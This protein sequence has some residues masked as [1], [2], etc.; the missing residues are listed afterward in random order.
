MKSTKLTAPRLRLILSI[1]LLVIIGI[2]GGIFQYGQRQL[3]S[4]AHTVAETGSQAEASQNDIQRLQTVQQQ[5]QQDADVVQSASDI[6]A[7]SKSYQYQNQIVTDLNSFAESA[8][9]TITNITFTSSSSS[10]TPTSG[11]APLNAG[12]PDKMLPGQPSTPSATTLKTVSA[13]ISMQNPVNYS[14]FL[15]FTHDIEQNLT[16]MQLQSL[17]LASSAGN[18]VSNDLT[19]QVY[20]R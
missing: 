19:I 11:S 15:Q 16:K 12:T 17:S 1:S 8:G 10:P 3:S 6:V 4:T 9:V 7:E 5:L 13:T 2:G 18:L 14:S 20:I